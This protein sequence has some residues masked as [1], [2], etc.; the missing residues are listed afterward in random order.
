MEK[1]D[2]RAVAG[3]DLTRPLDALLVN[4]PLRDYSIRPRVNDFTLPVLGMAYIATYAKRQGFNVGVLDAEAMGLSIVQTQ[5]IVNRLSPRWVGFNLLAPT[6]E[7]SARI[8]S[9]IREDV[10]IMAGGHQ[11]KAMPHEI[12]ADRRFAR[13]EALVLGEAETRVAAL[14][15]DRSSRVRLPGVMW[16]GGIGNG[17]REHLAPDINELP[18]VDRGFLLQDPY[19]AYDGRLESNIV[20]TRGCPYNCSF[21]GA[22][23]SA[24]PDVMIRTRTPHNI[25]DE[26]S[27]LHAAYG[28]T[29]F[30]FID[31]LFLGYERFIHRCMS[32]FQSARVGDR[33]VWDAT[34]RINILHRADDA[35]LD[36][37]AANGC[38]EIALDIE[39]GSARLLRYMGKRITPDMTRSVVRRLTE[40]GISV[41]G[42]FILGFPT[43]TREELA[44][45]IR[46]VRELW[47]LTEGRPGRFRASIFEF[48]PYPG[49]PEWHRLIATGRYTPRRLLAYTAVDLTDGGLDEAM[50]DRD[51][52]NF[53]VNMQ[54]GE[55]TVQEIRAHLVEL[56]REQYQRLHYW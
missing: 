11:A 27:E 36:T 43:E 3:A 29:A 4:A 9:G 17:S 50:H 24:N 25:L 47:D 12:L 46:H 23:V 34:G 53:S 49:T 40:R 48:R 6:Y 52:F 13:L 22:A 55:A 32:A 51:E 56:S 45:T 31:D 42:Y 16:N 30:R 15:G 10:C 41:K 1:S 33:W 8:A 19:R 5:Q 2:D 18:F 7:I 39:S 20:G 35:L 44:A 28:V 26:M 38:R 37:L 54:F 21:C 14:L